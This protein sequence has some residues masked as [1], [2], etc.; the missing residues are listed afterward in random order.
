MKRLIAI[1]IFALTLPLFSVAQSNYMPG[2]IVNLKGDTLHGYI[3][4]REWY[5]N[6]LSIDFKVKPSDKDARKLTSDDIKLFNVSDLVTYQAYRGQISMDRIDPEH[7]PSGRDVNYKTETIFLKILQKGANLTL[8]SYVDDIRPRFYIRQATDTTITEL[9]YRIYQANDIPS[10]TVKTVSENT[11]LRQLYALAQKYNVL[12]DSLQVDIEHITYSGPDI[13][14]IVTSI[15]KLPEPISQGKSAINHKNRFFAGAGIQVTMTSPYS[16][17]QDAAFSSH[18]SFLPMATLG[19]NFP[20]NPNV[21]K[22]LFRLEFSLSAN[23]YSSRYNNSV[24]SSN[25]TYSYNALVFA[26]ALQFVYNFYDT[27]KLK[28]FGG[29]GVA[30]SFYNYSNQAFKDADGKPAAVA[31]NPDAFDSLKIPLILKAGLQ[32]DKNYEVYLDYLTS[33]SS[34]N[35]AQYRLNFSSF[36]LGFN[37]QF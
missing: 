17:M 34:S 33:S 16:K 4:L 21:G 8:Y 29:G 36:Q 10:G 26:I 14:K 20:L 23:S 18:T 3:D 24:S 13:L 6:P 31:I 2:Y 22:L 5:I 19:W 9:T 15:N 11:Y 32:L 25:I 37:Y 1:V 35:A 28:I 12:T 27:E 30:V 7:I